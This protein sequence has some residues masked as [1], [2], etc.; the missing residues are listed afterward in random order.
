LYSSANNSPIN[1]CIEIVSHKLML[2]TGMVVSLYNPI[3]KNPCIEIA[4]IAC[5]AY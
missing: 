4:N 3:G 1:E 5:L 2:K